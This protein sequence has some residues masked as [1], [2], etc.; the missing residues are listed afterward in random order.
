MR[1]A[2]GAGMGREADTESKSQRT[3]AWNK[4][5]VVGTEKSWRGILKG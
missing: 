1:R 2:E 5:L 4:D 3:A